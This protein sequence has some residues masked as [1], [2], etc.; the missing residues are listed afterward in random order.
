M[1]SVARAM[2]LVVRRAAWRHLRS[3]VAHSSCRSVCRSANE[4]STLLAP[5]AAKRACAAKATALS[6]A[7]RK[8]ARDCVGLSP[9]RYSAKAARVMVRGG[10]WWLGREVSRGAGLE[11]V[12]TFVQ[13]GQRKAARGKDVLEVRLLRVGGRPHDAARH[14]RLRVLV[15]GERRDPLPVRPRAACRSQSTSP[16]L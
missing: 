7:C 14:V 9:E 15:P 8:L 11:A 1:A 13:G 12:R 16:R 3:N 4:T 6:A 5:G 2:G 10:S